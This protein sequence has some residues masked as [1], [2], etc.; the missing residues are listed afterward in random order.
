MIT[1]FVPLKSLVSWIS[2]I[3]TSNGRSLTSQ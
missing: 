3:Y 2:I 1:G